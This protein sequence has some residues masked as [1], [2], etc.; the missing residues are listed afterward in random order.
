[1]LT[2]YVFQKLNFPS[3]FSHFGPVCATNRYSS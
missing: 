2:L 3:H 1:L